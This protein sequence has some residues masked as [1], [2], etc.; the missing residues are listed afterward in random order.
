MTKDFQRS[1]GEGELRKNKMSARMTTKLEPYRN[2]NSS[3]TEII[4][5]GRTRKRKGV[6]GPEWQLRFVFRR[7]GV[8]APWRSTNDKENKPNGRTVVSLSLVA[9]HHRFGPQS[10]LCYLKVRK[11]IG[12]WENVADGPGLRNCH[13][14]FLFRRLQLFRWLYFLGF[15]QCLIAS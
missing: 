10:R 3:E 4:L 9:L 7:V 14:D 13:W 1:I 12:F 8:C 15:C 2:L 6:H 11:S 5:I